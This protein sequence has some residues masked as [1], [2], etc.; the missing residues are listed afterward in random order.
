MRLPGNNKIELCGSA[1]M[2]IVQAYLDD[3]TRGIQPPIRVVSIEMR[4]DVCGDAYI[5]GVTTDPKPEVL[6]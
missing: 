5:F 4:R 6:K 3:N 1:L 2:G